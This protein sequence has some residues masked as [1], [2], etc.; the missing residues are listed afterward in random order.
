MVRIICI[1]QIA[2]LGAVGF[3][4]WSKTGKFKPTKSGK[5]KPTLT[6]VEDFMRDAAKVFKSEGVAGKQGSLIHSRR[7]SH[8]DFSRI[9]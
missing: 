9:S 7:E 4:Q 8:E 3:E 6:V 2:R 5:F 1:Q